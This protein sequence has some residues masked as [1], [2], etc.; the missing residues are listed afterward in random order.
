MAQLDAQQYPEQLSALILYGYP[1]NPGD[2]LDAKQCIRTAVGGTEGS[3]STF[4]VGMKSGCRWPTYTPGPP[5]ASICAGTLELE[6][7][8]AP[9]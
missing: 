6:G 5:H 9:E 4:H 3:Q 8:C 7:P 1:F 2:S